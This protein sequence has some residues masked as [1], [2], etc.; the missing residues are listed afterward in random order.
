[1]KKINFKRFE[2]YNAISHKEVVV[3]DCREEFAN[4]IYL[5]G[6]GVACHA[7]AM[8]VYKSEGDTEFSEEEISMMKKF[9]DK[10]GSLAFNDSIDLNI[11]EI[12]TK[13]NDRE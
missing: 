12:E 6:N 4:I 9:A 11:K 10:F 2:I 7:L 13:E 1:M 8:K 5:N 3:H